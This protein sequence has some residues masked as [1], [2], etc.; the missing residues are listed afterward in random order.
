M[1]TLLDRSPL[2]TYSLL[3]LARFVGL[4][5]Y[6]LKKGFREVVGHTV[7]G[8]FNDL[9]MPYAHQLVCDSSFTIGDV[10]TK[11]GYSETH[12]F[13]SAFKRKFGYLPSQL[14][15]KSR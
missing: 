14:A 12:H 3:Q 4:N 10:A 8:Y 2:D 6:K 5:D 9:R 13:S 15:N 1:K 7:F 11:L